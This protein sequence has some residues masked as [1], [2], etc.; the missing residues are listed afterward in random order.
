MLRRMKDEV[1]KHKER[2]EELENQLA[3]QRSGRATPSKAMM[4]DLDAL[5]QQMADLRSAS[6]KANN[7]ND[8]LQ[9]RMLTLQAEYDR[10][11]QQQ[12]TESTTRIDGL[13]AELESLER[14]REK[15]QTDLAQTLTLNKQLNEQLRAALKGN[16]GGA[17][18]NAN[19]TGR[20]Q[21]IAKLE[22]DLQSA[23]NRVE[24][25]K[26]ENAALEARCRESES[27]I[28]ILLDAWQGRGVFSFQSSKTKI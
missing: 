5:K 26:R 24:W 4:G 11:L 22:A 13:E 12:E 15:I 19:S 1:N 10:T 7:E 25:L 9:R 17:N 27:K 16:N 21:E 23:E 8:E 28:S 20:T 3:E 6:E 18:G 14:E 2:N